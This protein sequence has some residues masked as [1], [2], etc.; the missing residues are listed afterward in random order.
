MRPRFTR[1]IAVNNTKAACRTDARVFAGAARRTYTL[2]ATQI[3]RFF[4]GAFMISPHL[5]DHY[6][7]EYR[8]RKSLNQLR[9]EA[10]FGG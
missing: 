9:F 2:G 3:L 7:G 4:S 1:R 8:G 6:S 10:A 5:P